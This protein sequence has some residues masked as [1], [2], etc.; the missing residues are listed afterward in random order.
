MKR[1]VVDRIGNA[2]ADGGNSFAEEEDLELV[3]DAT[4]FGLKT[5]ESLLAQSPRHRGLLQAA[6]AGFT[7]YAYA[8][9]QEEADFIEARDLPRAT[10]QRLRAKKLYLRARGYGLR[11][12]DEALPGFSSRIRTE[13]EA[14]LAQIPPA[15][16][17]LLYYTAASWAG[18]FA[19]DIT[20]AHLAVDQTLIEK[21]MRRALALDETWQEGAIHGFFIAWEAGHASAGGSFLEAR[22]HFDRVQAL[23]HGCNAAA[24]VSLAE[25]VSLQIQDRAEFERLLRRCLALDPNQIPAQRLATLVAQR[26]AA[27]LL[28]RMDDLFLEPATPGKELNS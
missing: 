5:L 20:D 2:L 17:P 21:M 8:F 7:Q 15:Q 10:A 26:R 14:A 25:A 1:I 16:V 23:A 27:W 4:P 6:C 3:R 28:S 11:A 22:R 9:V 18:A 19:L 13:P 24:Y 12:L